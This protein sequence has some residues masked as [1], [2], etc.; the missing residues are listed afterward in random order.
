MIN[1][2]KKISDIE[3]IC[4][5]AEKNNVIPKVIHRLLLYDNDFPK[6]L[7]SFLFELKSC[8]DNFLHILWTEKDLL[9]IMNT[10]ESSIYNSYKRKIQKSDYGRYIVLKYYG[11]IYF[12][13]DI[14]MLKKLSNFYEKYKENDLFFEE[15]THLFLST[16]RNES[17]YLLRIANYVMMNKKFSQHIQGILDICKERYL[18]PIYNE[19]DILYTTGPDVT[20]TYVNENLHK[21]LYIEKN[22]YSRYFIHTHH[23]HWHFNKQIN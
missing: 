14:K 16:K 17:P 3:D 7:K 5:K 2:Y 10:E 18:L 15:F 20:T 9:T 8:N 12:D 19:E 21:V 1:T 11:G 6:D 23:G 13:F 4:N 22:E